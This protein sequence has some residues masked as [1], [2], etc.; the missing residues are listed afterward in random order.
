QPGIYRHTICALEFNL[1][2]AGKD[3]EGVF[4]C[5]GR[6]PERQ[7]WPDSRLWHFLHR[8]RTDRRPRHPSVR[9][10]GLLAPAK[11][12]GPSHCLGK[13]SLVVLVQAFPPTPPAPPP[14]IPS[15]FAA[16]PLSTAIS[17]YPLEPIYATAS[18][19]WPRANVSTIR[20]T[21][22]VPTCSVTSP[23]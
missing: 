11:A 16:L 12:S 13:S 3:P 18:P 20:V 6:T 1:C 23:C 21:A 7:A 8:L 10:I 22:C 17:T 15:V 4:R 9:H 14:P 5:N 2:L 19:F